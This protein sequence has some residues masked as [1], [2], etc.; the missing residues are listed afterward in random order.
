MEVSARYPLESLD[1]LITVTLNPE[2][3]SIDKIT[4]DQIDDII[5]NINIENTRIQTLINSQVFSTSKVD[6]TNLLIKKYYSSL[7]VLL[8][9]AIENQETAPRINK[10][11]DIYVILIRN[12][13]DLFSFIETRYPECISLDDRVS[14]TYFNITKIELQQRIKKI[15]TV[16]IDQ[17]S[18][19]KMVINR[20]THFINAST[21]TYDITF[22]V[23]LYKKELVKGLEDVAWKRN[24]NEIYSHLE[25]LL[26]YLNFNSKTF[27]NMVTYR[28]AEITNTNHHPLDRIDKLLYFYKSYKQLHRKPNVIL[29]PKNHDLDTAISNWFTQEIFYLEKKM[30]LSVLPLDKKV[31]QKVT[32]EQEEI[33]KQKVLC[34]LSIDQIG[35]I[36]R[37]SDELRVIV[38]KSMNQVFRTI[39][40]HLSTPYKE[41][42]SYDSMRS[43]SYVAEERDKQIA[44]ETLQKIINK[45]KDY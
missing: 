35:L 8:D 28:I 39:V 6:E 11:K 37:A 1:L 41:N 42:I 10:Y 20:L 26:I 3:N 25:K 30:R 21:Y 40:P 5:E 32:N 2:R 34:I 45:I 7:T 33:I 38:A 9:Q 36:L 44:I 12:L 31:E 19:M 4:D 17:S 29:N 22:R 43:K 15:K 13:N 18:V 24:E 14:A 16:N 27:M 23:L